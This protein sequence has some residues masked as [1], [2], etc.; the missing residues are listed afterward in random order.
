MQARNKPLATTYWIQWLCPSTVGE[1]QQKPFRSPSDCSLDFMAKLRRDQLILLL[2]LCPETTF[3]R[4][5]QWWGDVGW[6]EVWEEA[7]QHPP[8]I[9]LQLLQWELPRPWGQSAHAA[10]GQWQL[11]VPWRNEFPPQTQGHAAR[12]REGTAKMRGLSSLGMQ[13][14]KHWK[15]A[16]VSNFLGEKRQVSYW[17]ICIVR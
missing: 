15:K 1:Q 12:Q 10:A 13:F 17:F 11:A 9:H 16:I 8:V 5:L 4:H 14:L 2:P 7:C 3:S 6:Y